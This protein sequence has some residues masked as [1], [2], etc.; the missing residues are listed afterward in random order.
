VNN[1]RLSFQLPFARTFVLNLNGADKRWHDFLA[2]NNWIACESK[3]VRVPTIGPKRVRPPQAWKKTPEA[4]AFTR[5]KQA[6]FEYCLNHRIPSAMV[7]LDSARQVPDYQR[8]TT[9]FEIEIPDDWRL[10]F[11]GGRLA[12][13][14]SCVPIQRN[15]AV[16]QVRCVKDV[17]AFAWRGYPMLERLYHSSMRNC[18]QPMVSHDFAESVRD[19][20]GIYAPHR[21]FFQAGATS[22]IDI[23]SIMAEA[24]QEIIVVLGSF[25][26]GTS[27]VAGIL[28]RLGISM[29]RETIHVDATNPKGYFE[30]KRLHRLC[31]RVFDYPSLGRKLTSPEIIAQL[32]YWANRRSTQESKPKMIGAKHPTLSCLG[33]EI[34]V[35]WPKARFVVVDREPSEILES[36]DRTRWGWSRIEAMLATN[37]L[38]SARQAFLSSLSADSFCRI[39]FRKL[40]SDRETE[41]DRLIKWLGIHTTL[42]Q[43]TA[44]VEHVAISAGS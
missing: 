42:E 35:A 1:L 19:S 9:E 10:L 18:G 36:I 25:R 21:W 40:R 4:W 3:F 8:I 32:R 30:C 22:A 44:A 38:L 13:L 26:G 17:H 43:R 28:D 37:R 29:G 24:E 34:T 7:I 2:Q 16:Y 14:P 11:F 23:A 31:R 41:V 5:G 33:P 15:Y 12:R 6:V 39:D 27:C 20:R